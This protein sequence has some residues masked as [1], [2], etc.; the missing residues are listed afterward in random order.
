[1]ALWLFGFVA[2][3]LFGRAGVSPLTLLFVLTCA[4][5]RARTRPAVGRAVVFFA[6]FAWGF[7]NAAP[8]K[9]ANL[10][11]VRVVRSDS[12]LAAPRPVIIEADGRRFQ[13]TAPPGQAVVGSLRFKP[14]NGA[15]SGG[16]S[17]F[18][19]RSQGI[20]DDSA[21]ASAVAGLRA[22]FHS[23]LEVDRPFMRNWFAGILLGERT[24]LPRRV[25]AAFKSTGT[26]H[27]L[28]V[29][30][31]HVSLLVVALSLVLRA[32]FQLAYALRL[33]RPQLW[34]HVASGLNILA[35]VLALLYLGIAGMPAAAQRS[36]FTYLVIQLGGVTIGIPTLKK[37]L[38]LAAGLQTL[39]FPI[40]FLSE[41]CLMSWAAYLLVIRGLRG[42][43]LWTQ[44]QLTVMAAAAFGQLPLLGILANLVLVPVFSLL[45]VLGLV[46]VICGPA[47]P[48]RELI[49]AMHSSFIE[50]VMGLGQL[51]E[52]FPWLS[53]SGDR[54]PAPCRGL[55]WILSAIFLLNT[56]RIL[57]IDQCELEDTR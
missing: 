57:S 44:V 14:R 21:F 20:E 28:A 6:A 22:W 15:L 37:R 36:V 39:F 46:A 43:M 47:L 5:S 53:L 24:V 8:T 42:R 27:L 33:I 23:R 41:G 40:G 52:A 56:C 1:M 13:A 16:Q 11:N 50:I 34:R 51:I 7:A 19:A 55:F 12:P 4:L 26:Y 25:A 10:D 35:A 48:G 38:L 18:V 45:L 2:G 29:S 49:L 9:E 3:V 54:L 30:G 17:T 32:P 31:L